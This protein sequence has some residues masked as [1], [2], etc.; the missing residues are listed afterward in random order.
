MDRVVGPN[1]GQIGSEIHKQLFYSSTIK[2]FPMW[3]RL[4]L[5]MKQWLFVQSPQDWRSFTVVAPGEILSYMH[6][7]FVF[8]SQAVP[9]SLQPLLAFPCSNARLID[10]QLRD[11]NLDPMQLHDKNMQPLHAF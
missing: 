9:F 3:L 8:H 11:L 7:H 6:F 1:S 2:D 5:L 4:F 10:R